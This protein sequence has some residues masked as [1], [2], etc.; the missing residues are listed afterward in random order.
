MNIF[1]IQ[2][3][4]GETGENFVDECLKD[5]R[6]TTHVDYAGEFLEKIRPGDIGI[7]HRGSQAVCLIKIKY[8]ITNPSEISGTSFGQ[9]YKIEIL[10]YWNDVSDVNDW[11]KQGSNVGHNS[12]FTLLNSDSKK[13]YPFIK[14]WYRSIE[15]KRMKTDLIEL[16]EYKKQLILQ[17]PPGTG[18]TRLAKEI[19]L[20]LVD[21]SAQVEYK[22][23]GKLMTPA[24]YDEQVSIVQFHPSYTYEDFVRGISVSTNEEGSPE[25]KTVNRVLGQLAKRA[26]DATIAN[27]VDDFARA[28]QALVKDIADGKVSKVGTSDVEVEL[29][30]KGN[31]KFKTPV[32]TYE[33]TYSLYRTGTTDLVYENYHVI[34][35]RFLKTK[36]GLKDYVAGS[37]MDPGQAKNYVLIIDEINRANLASV[38]G[39]LVYALE[40]RGDIVQSMYALDG[41]PA[42]TAR[43]IVLPPNLYIIGTMNTAD[44]SVGHIDYAIRRRFAFESIL[45]QDLSASLGEKFAKTE[46]DQVQELFSKQAD[47]TSYLSPE[48]HPDD[49]RI[50]HSYFIHDG[51]KEHKEMRLRYEVL[52]ILNEYVKDGVLEQGAKEEIDSWNWNVTRA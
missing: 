45:P 19:A 25:Y 29:N 1:K 31:I 5:K 52:P 35:L 27:G 26:Q 10:Q 39:E 28:W 9:D 47:G 40:Y 8:K 44:R 13:V 38:L 24:G 17:G 16:L 20:K 43:D 42:A 46:F 12:T 21:G 14:S 30:S 11:K 3:R 34:V 48:F 41:E 32:A 23:N 18:K 7:V 49:V 22:E 4:N 33:N 6:I 37:E 15:S 36:Y 50:G 2:I 51:T